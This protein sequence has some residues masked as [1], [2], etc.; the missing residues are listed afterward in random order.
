M[1]P[2]CWREI[3]AVDWYQVKLFIEHSSGASMDA[4]HVIMGV[5]AQVAVAF[6]L[7]TSL[8]RWRPWLFALA[9][10]IANE[11]NDLW[12]ETWP[13]WGMQWG[14]AAKDMTLTMALPT[15]LLLM[16]RFHP[17]LFQS[18]PRAREV[19]RDDQLVFDFT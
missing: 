6:V 17:A 15:L 1:Q 11:V 4:L 7:R 19:V 13:D 10:E 3:A 2:I 14:E 5:F 12:V 8:S 9:I 16:V 18:A